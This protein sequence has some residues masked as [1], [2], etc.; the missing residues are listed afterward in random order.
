MARMESS[1][2]NMASNQTDKHA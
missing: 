1:E 2:C